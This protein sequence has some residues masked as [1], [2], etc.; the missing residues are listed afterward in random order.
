MRKY[1]LG[2]GTNLGNCLENLRMCVSLLKERCTV[3][4]VSKVYTTKPWGI[5]NQ[6]D[7]LNMC[8]CVETDLLEEEFFVFVMGIERKIGRE[9]RVKNGPRIIDVDIILCDKYAG[10]FSSSFGEVCIPHKEMH[11]R[12]TVLV[13]LCDIAADVVHPVLKENVRGLCKQVSCKGVEVFA[14]GL[15]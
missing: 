1:Y 5:F 8:V 7:F 4:L 12:A 13:P 14:D 10:T 11:K 15:N 2:L 9:K 6:P 3:V